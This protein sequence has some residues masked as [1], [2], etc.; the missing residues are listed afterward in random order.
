M[1]SQFKEWRDRQKNGIFKLV[2]TLCSSLARCK[3]WSANVNV[4]T[5]ETANSLRPLLKTHL[6][7]KITAQENQHPINYAHRILITFHLSH[8]SS[9]KHG[10]KTDHQCFK[11]LIRISLNI[12][13]K[14]KL[15]FYV[16]PFL[17][18]LQLH[19]T[20]KKSKQT[21]SKLKHT[22]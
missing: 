11:L 17:A 3:T 22:E 13:I 21:T 19:E 9:V 10:F 5:W 1:S 7:Q 18:P 15:S 2:C 6:F 20:S 4:K 8:S 14:T 16:W 12:S